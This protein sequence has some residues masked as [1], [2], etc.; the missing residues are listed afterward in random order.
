[1]WNVPIR[2]VSEKSPHTRDVLT[3]IAYAQAR[4]VYVYVYVYTHTHMWNTE[5]VA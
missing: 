1:M 3:A 2:Y 4:Y 5:K